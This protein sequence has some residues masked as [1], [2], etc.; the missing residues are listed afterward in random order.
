M[1]W[2]RGNHLSCVSSLF[3][4]GGIIGATLGLT[5]LLGVMPVPRTNSQ[6]IGHY[7]ERHRLGELLHRAGGRQGP[8]RFF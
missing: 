4:L 8:V 1:G 6:H 3:A 7:G 5:R 2:C